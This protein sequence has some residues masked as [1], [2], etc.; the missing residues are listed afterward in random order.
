MRFLDFYVWLSRM[1]VFEQNKR[2]CCFLSLFSSVFIDRW[3]ALVPSKYQRK[4]A[5]WETEFFGLESCRVLGKSL[6][7]FCLLWLNTQKCLQSY[8]LRIFRSIT[9]YYIANIAWRVSTTMFCCACIRRA[10]GYIC[11]ATVCVLR[12]HSGNNRLNLNLR[13]GNDIALRKGKR[14]MT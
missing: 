11:G 9:I 6:L 10:M 14:H 13:F 7:F 2:N 8:Y 4:R 12:C 3:T 5:F 1:S